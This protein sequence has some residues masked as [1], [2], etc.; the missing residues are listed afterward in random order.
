MFFKV[1]DS[2]P[3]G[4]AI[5]QLVV[6]FL[7]EKTGTHSEH[8][9]MGRFTQMSAVEPRNADAATVDFRHEPHHEGNRQTFGETK[10]DFN[11]EILV[12]RNSEESGEVLRHLYF[13]GYRAEAAA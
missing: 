4:I 7:T 1:F 5:V 11:N 9:A 13:A 2:I 10:L 12:D 3:H 6:K 8:I